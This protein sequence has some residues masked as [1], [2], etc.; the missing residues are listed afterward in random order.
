[1]MF[2]DD[3]PAQ[4]DHF[5]HCLVVL[6]RDR[7][8]DLDGGMQRARERRVLDDRDRMLTGDLPDLQGHRV[9]ALGDADRDLPMPRSYCRATE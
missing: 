4:H 2:C 5:G 7:L 9:D 3:R 1:M 6:D 8:V